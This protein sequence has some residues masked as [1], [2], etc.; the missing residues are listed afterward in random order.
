MLSQKHSNT[1]PSPGLGHVY[2]PK[3]F[4]L[5]MIENF[6]STC[7]CTV[8][9]LKEYGTVQN[10]GS[11]EQKKSQDFVGETKTRIRVKFLTDSISPNEKEIDASL[12]LY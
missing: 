7:L 9:K 8:G 10:P 2:D 6:M 1:T 11:S 3:I 4:I 5:W 12:P